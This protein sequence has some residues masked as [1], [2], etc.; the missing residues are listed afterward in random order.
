MKRAL[1]FTGW[2][3]TLLT[4]GIA[5]AQPPANDSCPGFAITSLPY[6]YSG[7]TTNCV[8]SYGYSCP[9]GNMTLRDVVFTLTLP[10]QTEV[11]VS[12]CDSTAF[13]A[14]LIIRTGGACPG[15]DSYLCSSDWCG[16][17]YNRGQQMFRAMP[18][19]P[20]YIL[21]G[22]DNSLT[23]S[24]PYRLEVTAAPPPPPNDYCPGFAITS[25]P[26]TYE[27]NNI[28]ASTEYEIQCN[29]AW[30]W[31]DM[32]FSM[33]LPTAQ[34]VT[35]SLCDGTDFNAQ[36]E[37]YS[38][39]EC[40]G[41]DYV[42]CSWNS[43]G[44]GFE[45]GSVTFVAAANVT[46]YLVVSGGNVPSWGNYRLTVIGPPSNDTC[47]GTAITSLPFTDSGSTVGAANDYT[48]ACNGIASMGGD[49]VY[50]LMLPECY[51]VTASLCGSTYD[52]R[53]MMRAGPVCSGSLRFCLQR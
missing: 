49:V 26:Y 35:A 43:C 51:E 4:V 17:G 52:T 25:L 13:D 10:Q 28:S 44:A 2:I 9:P 45:R 27:G 11:I 31:G 36:L 1:K 3:F 33:T 37:V 23:A 32:F 20:Y 8:Q 19:V 40:P 47:P 38:G 48:Y 18:G 24:G 34:T 42:T 50:H 5:L 6:V 16:P 41:N 14:E 22:G 7:N 29:S 53:L 12:L 30:N 46:Y 21:V 39:G 15:T